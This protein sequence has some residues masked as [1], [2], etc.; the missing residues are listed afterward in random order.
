MTKIKQKQ[1]NNLET[2]LSAKLAK[3][4]GTM[5]G[6]LTLSG[7]PTNAL[8]SATKQYVD[9]KIVSTV[10]YLGG[11]NASTNSP[12]LDTSPSGV[13]KGDMYTV[14]ASGNFFTV[15][16][17]IGDVLI[18]EADDASTEAEWTIV[19]K[20]LDAGSIKTAYE[21]NSYSNAFSDAEKT[22]L[23]NQSG[24]NTGDEPNASTTTRGIVELA[25]NSEAVTGTD[26]ARAVTPAGLKAHTDALDLSSSATEEDVACPVTTASTNFT[27]DVATAPT[28]GI[29]GVMSIAINGV[30][31][32]AGERV[33][34]SCTTITL[35][36]PYAVDATDTVTV[37]YI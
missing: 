20:N 18:A 9:G 35:N 17:E 34:G 26:T 37:R 15:A 4:G 31:V 2:D 24:S 14:T 28:G 33:S 5:T 8:H 32:S 21:S 22:Q 3:A 16:V 7:D 30:A 27:V 36:V 25:T 29:A 13:K 12:D 6:A 10:D 11:Y 1:I 19:N 23:F